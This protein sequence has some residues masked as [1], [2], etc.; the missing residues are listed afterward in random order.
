MTAG[1]RLL[2]ETVFRSLE[3]VSDKRV[4]CRADTAEG[5]GLFRCRMVLA[6]DG[7]HSVVARAAGLFGRRPQNT[8]VAVRGYYEDVAC[9]RDGIELYLMPDFQPGYAWVIPL[10][11]KVANIGMGIRSDACVHKRIRLHSALRRFVEGHPTLSRRTR[12]A[13]AL[14]PAQGWP[15][16]TYDGSRKLSAPHV[17]LVGEAAGLVDPL[18]GEG[19]FGALLS[20]QLA[21][22]VVGEA[23]QK[24]DYSAGSLAAYDRNCR[25]SFKADYGSA[26][27]LTGLLTHRFLGKLALWGLNRVEARSLI[28]P[29]YAAMIA[30]FFTATEPRRRFLTPRW[31]VRTLVG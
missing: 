14:C 16:S 11:R 15:I 26:A 8:I 17:L 25:A 4:L 22:A 6:A 10:S 31:I 2:Y 30:G 18:T 5:D 28:D 19:I 3:I 21:A 27:F 13:R 23:L 12:Q 20:G 1:C 24:D 9:L 29:H 7:V